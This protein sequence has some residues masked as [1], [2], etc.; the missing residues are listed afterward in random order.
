MAEGA[1]DSLASPS[2]P[3]QFRTRCGG[4][5]AFAGGS[6]FPTWG[7][8][9]WQWPYV[10][11]VKRSDDWATRC[12]GILAREAPRAVYELEHYGCGLFADEAGKSTSVR[13]GGHTRNSAEGAPRFS[14]PVPQPTGR[15]RDPSHAWFGQFA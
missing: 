11:T 7:P 8:E 2:F 12:D 1:E 14:V 10:D 6:L 9:Q 3:D 13:I 4:R 15:P 5:A